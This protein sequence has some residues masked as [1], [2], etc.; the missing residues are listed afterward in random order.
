MMF[1]IYNLS[2]TATPYTI[3]SCSYVIIALK[4][5]VK[6]AYILFVSNMEFRFINSNLHFPYILIQDIKNDD[7]LI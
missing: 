3:C 5:N 2:T 6:I 4:V 7:K 1:Y